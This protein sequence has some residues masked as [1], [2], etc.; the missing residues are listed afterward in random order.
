MAGYTDCGASSEGVYEYVLRG[1]LVREWYIM[2]SERSTAYRCSAR[3]RM[4]P[5]TVRLTKAHSG[6]DV[7]NHD[8]ADMSEA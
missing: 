7:V 6:S 8:G 1:M 3:S 5:F 2:S 4:R